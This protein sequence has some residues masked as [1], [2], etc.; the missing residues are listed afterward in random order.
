MLG[1]Q[2]DL[3]DLREF[4]DHPPCV[5]PG[6]P[7]LWLPHLLHHLVIAMSPACVQVTVKGTGREVTELCPASARLGSTASCEYV[8]TGH[9]GP[10]YDQCCPRG[11]TAYY[12]PERL[13]I[14][15]GYTWLKGK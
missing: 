15:A 3:A 14:S 6:T 2:V 13:Q 5:P 7:L 1:W 9:S 12:T 10:N 11:V 8:V 4:V